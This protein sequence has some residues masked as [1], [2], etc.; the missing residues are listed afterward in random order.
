[1]KVTL[2]NRDLVI[3]KHEGTLIEGTELN[4]YHTAGKDEYDSGTIRE[5]SKGLYIEWDDNTEDT[6][7]DG[8]HFAT[9]ILKRCGWG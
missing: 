9:Q 7:L 6:Q 5:N 8:S 2:Y 1:M 4:F 3:T